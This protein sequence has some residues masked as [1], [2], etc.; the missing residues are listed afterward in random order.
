METLSATKIQSWL[1]W[2]LRGLL[3]LGF[4][5]LFGRLFELQVVR[6][7]YFRNLA[8][9]N[10]IRRIPITAARGQ[11]IARGGEILVGNEKVNKKII[12]TDSGYEK[13]DDIEDA[14]GVDLITEWERSYPLQEKIAHIS[15]YLG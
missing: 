14:Q 6:G 2:F 12:F 1:V 7:E 11:I 9:G 13:T 4:L 3:V 8:E 10:R 15:G 5:V